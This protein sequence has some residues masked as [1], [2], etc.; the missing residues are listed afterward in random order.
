[1]KKNYQ[2][3]NKTISGN[4]FLK[5]AKAAEICVS[6]VRLLMPSRFAMSAFVKPSS[7]LIKNTRR[8]CSGICSISCMTICL[9]SS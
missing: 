1:M 7:R 2:M 9:N 8:R 6:T 4:I 5:S 3:D